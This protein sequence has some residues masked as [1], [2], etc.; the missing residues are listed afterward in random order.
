MCGYINSGLKDEIWL[1]IA[2]ETPNAA[3]YKK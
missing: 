3:L 2:R 1:I